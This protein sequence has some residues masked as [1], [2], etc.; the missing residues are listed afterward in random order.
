MFTMIN[1]KKKVVLMNIKAY[2]YFSSNEFKGLL[3]ELKDKYKTYGY[4]TGVIYVTQN[5]FGEAEKLSKF[6]SMN[7]KSNIIIFP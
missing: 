4:T 1:S 6:L 5:S 3:K 2:N 7:I